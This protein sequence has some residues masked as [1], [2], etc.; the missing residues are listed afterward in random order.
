MNRVN[1]R[2]ICLQETKLGNRDFN[3]GLNFSFYKSQ[4]PISEHAKGGT[5][6]IVDNAT[7]HSLVNIDTSLQAVAV[8]VLFDRF[9]T[10]CSL[11]LPDS[12]TLHDLENLISTSISLFDLGRC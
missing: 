11:Y 7:D 3:P 2:V 1:P 9:I 10:I 6:I 12:F 4:L 8:R 5:G